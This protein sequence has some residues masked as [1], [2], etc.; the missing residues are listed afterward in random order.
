V[1]LR[2]NHADIIITFILT[3]WPTRIGFPDVTSQVTELFAGHPNLI[4]GLNPFLPPSYPNTIC[5]TGHPVTGNESTP[6]T[7]INPPKSSV[8]MAPEMSH[9]M[10]ATPPNTP[11]ELSEPVAPSTIHEI[12]GSTGM[13]SE[14]LGIRT[15]MDPSHPP[16]GVPHLAYLAPGAL[17][18]SQKQLEVSISF[19][20]IAI[21]HPTPT[22]F[23]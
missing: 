18:L 3:H 16:G 12:G 21:S 23:L 5:A 11:T 15:K 20:F 1:S 8:I 10:P 17:A 22:M 7:H 9:Q 19:P 13:L 6:I 2:A 4:Q 14:Q